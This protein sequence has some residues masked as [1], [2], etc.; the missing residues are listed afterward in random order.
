MQVMVTAVN[1]LR[2]IHPALRSPTGMIVH[3]DW[4][5]NVL[6]FKR[7]NESG[8]AHR[9]QRLPARLPVR[10]GRPYLREAVVF[11]A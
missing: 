2:W 6:A 7:W 10:L 4:N 1:H 11:S 9:Y 5:N 8:D 3:E